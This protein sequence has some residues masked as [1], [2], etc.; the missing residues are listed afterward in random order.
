MTQPF[1][2]LHDLYERARAGEVMA[3]KVCIATLNN[4]GCD[5]LASGQKSDPKWVRYY[6]GLQTYL[7]ALVAEYGESETS[8]EKE[9]LAEVNAAR[10]Y[11]GDVD[12]ETK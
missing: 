9:V 3:R 7:V 11:A 8:A 10:S 4:F 12:L 1:K 6:R 5:H 2:S